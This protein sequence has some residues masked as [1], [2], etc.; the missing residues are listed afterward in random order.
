MNTK[1]YKEVQELEKK[2]YQAPELAIENLTKA[3][4]ESNQKLARVMRERDDIFSNISHDLRSPITTIH[5]SLEYLLEQK[6]LSK[7]EISETLNIM[8]KRT[9]TLEHM[10]ENIFL[11]TKLKSSNQLFSFKNVP[12]GSFL[13]DLFY[14]RMVEQKYSERKLMINIPMDFP[15]SANIDIDYLTRAIDNLLENALKASKK[16]DII[17]LEALLLDEFHIKEIVKT[18]S[19][20]TC[21]SDKDID[22]FIHSNPDTTY[23]YIKIWNTGSIMTQD[24]ISHIFERTYTAQNARTPSSKSGIGLG[25]TICRSIIE[26]HE[27]KIWCTSIPT[28]EKCIFNIL[29]PVYSM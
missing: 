13:E 11:L 29:L 12:I 20:G 17:S 23:C 10:V 19:D 21:I 22:V 6:D 26:K 8:Y 25:L 18:Q 16:D 7:E 9:L 28:E 27:G 3:L 1:D 4:Y 15:Y 2:E 5:N 24:M 14:Q